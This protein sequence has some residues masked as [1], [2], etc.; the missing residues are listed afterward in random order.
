MSALKV[1]IFEYDRPFA[2]A[3]EQAFVRRGCSV[4]IV[5]DGQLGLEVALDDRPDLILLSIE[6]PR[7]N[8]FAVCNRIKKHPDLKDVPLVILSSDSPPETFEQHS[9]LRTRA[10]DYVHKPVDPD[11][12]VARAAT[13]V[14]V[15]GLAESEIMVDEEAVEIE[16]S[17]AEG[18]PLDDVAGLADAAFDSIMLADG[19]HDPA[20]T[21]SA[22]AVLE[23]APV[24]TEQHPSFESEGFDDFT[25]VSSRLELPLDLREP[26]RTSDRTPDR[27]SQPARKASSSSQSNPRVGVS[28]PVPPPSLS[29]FTPPPPSGPSEAELL[30]RRVA[31]LEIQLSTAQAATQRVVDL[32]EE[33]QRLRAHGDE[34]ARVTK[35][36]EEARAKA[37]AGPAPAAATAAARPGGIST[38][39]FLELRESLNR[40]DKE[41]LARDR[42]IL[43]LRDKVLQGE[44]GAADFEERVAERDAVLAEV[45]GALEAETARRTFEEGAKADALPT[46]DVPRARLSAGIPAFELLH[47]AGLA[48][49]LRGDVVVRQA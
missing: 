46:V 43:E 16:P 5:D 28:P 34:L 44:M 2:E 11:A 22:A 35:E 36:L 23:P 10:E 13:F 26:A 7:M 9:K 24:A 1:L 8:G 40:K 15:P 32:T 6:L 38:R 39:E 14:R 48:A 18:S 4:R 30:Q 37:A 27:G 21:A 47:E 31:E 29:S 49:E 17:D 3:V 33:N 41:I 45:R 12:L 20:A 42:E 19:A 25:M